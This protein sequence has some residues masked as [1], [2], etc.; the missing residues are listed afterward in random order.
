MVV[1]IASED[2]SMFSCHYDI[3]LYQTNIISSGEQKKHAICASRLFL[4]R[5]LVF[6][7]HHKKIERWINHEKRK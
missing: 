2:L 5:V 7:F 6:D 3:Y 4:K 1:A